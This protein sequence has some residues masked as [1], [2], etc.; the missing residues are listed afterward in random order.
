ML[1]YETRK[2]YRVTVRALDPSAESAQITVTINV[3]D[4][5]EPP[6][7]S[8]KGLAALG[9][10]NVLYQENGSGTVGQYTA[11]GPNA[12]NVSWRLSGRDASDFSISSAGQLTF[13][14]TPNFES[15]ADS[16]RDNIYD[17]T[18]TARSGS[19]Q[20]EVEVTVEVYNVDEEGAV[21]LSHA[22]GHRRVPDHG[23]A[24]GP[25]R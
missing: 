18:V 14:S 20:D 10:G 25:R 23:Y 11:T 3:R 5:D 15:P 9:D 16:D 4:V 2:S 8:E 22:R 6:E 12:N 7:L 13:R 17:I 24:D 19:V 1:D 21:A